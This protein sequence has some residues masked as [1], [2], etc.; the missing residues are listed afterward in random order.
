VIYLPDVQKGFYRGSRFDWS[1]LVA[2][3]EYKGRTYFGEL[4]RPHDPLVHDHAVGT[5]EEFGMESGLGYDE[6]APGETFIKIGIGRLEKP[7]GEKRYSFWHPYRIVETFPWRIEAHEDRVSF[8]QEAS[9]SRGWGYVY[10]KVVMLAVEEPRLTIRH[11][12]KNTGSRPIRTQHY[13]H[14]MICL[15]QQP[16]G[17]DYTLRFPVAVRTQQQDRLDNCGARVQGSEI[18]FTR[19]LD[20]SLWFQLDADW[21]KCE[22]WVEIIQRRTGT[23]L[24]IIGNWPIAKFCVYAESTAVCPEPFLDIILAPGEEKSWDIYYL[25]AK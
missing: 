18:A 12:F 23:K 14:N 4:K 25:F 2:Q 21:A 24:K 10:T 19:L 3:V 1:G 17:E 6:A 15:D 7:E 11:V 8:C 5:C 9:D 13:S 20:G 16:F 22:N